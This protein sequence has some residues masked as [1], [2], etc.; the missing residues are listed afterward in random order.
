MLTKLVIEESAIDMETIKN[1]LETMFVNLPN[2]QKVQKAK[3]E[4]WQ[5]MEDKYTELKRD[6]KSENEAIGIV[7]SEFGNLDEL[8]Q[9]LGIENYIQN[10]NLT[11]GKIISLETVKEFLR[12]KAKTAYMIALGVFFC[13]ISPVGVM[14]GSDISERAE[15]VGLIYMFVVIAIAVGLFVFSGIMMDKWKFMKNEVCNIAFETTN[16]VHEKNE[17]YRINYA[18]IMTIGV[19]FCVISLVPVVALEESNLL[20]NIGVSLFLV[21]VAI[22]VFLIVAASVKKDGFNTILKLN[23]EGTIGDE[24]VHSQKNVTYNN[25]IVAGVMSVYWPTVTCIYLIWSFLTFDWYITWIIWIIA[26]LMETLI[27]NVFSDSY[28]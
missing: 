13:I 12:E 5:M 20:E 19:V 2:T 23:K 14:L 18:T 9:D 3:Y 11:V 21:C 28:R 22:G 16:Y 15:I 17:E 4:L 8:S 1:Y 10:E 24:Y 26:G 27:K 6:G 7:I 25:K